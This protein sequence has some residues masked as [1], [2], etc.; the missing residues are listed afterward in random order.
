[1]DSIIS[2]DGHLKNGVDV[3]KIKQVV[4]CVLEDDPNIKVDFKTPFIVRYD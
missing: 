4:V 1:M 2:F 3:K